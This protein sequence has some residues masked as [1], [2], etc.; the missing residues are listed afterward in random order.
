MPP[1]FKEETYWSWQDREFK[2]VVWATE[3]HARTRNVFF[4]IFHLEKLLYDGKIFAALPPGMLFNP[5][6]LFNGPWV[7]E[8]KDLKNI[9]DIF[10]KVK[11]EH[12]E[13]SSQIK[14]G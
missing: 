14:K 11:D 4:Q 12:A 9:L 10:Q 6:E 3:L 13:S 8:R 2:L 5:N 7:Q 1:N